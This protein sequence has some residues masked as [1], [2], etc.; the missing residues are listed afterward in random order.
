M[1]NQYIYNNVQNPI[2]N[3]STI[4]KMIE[5]YASSS[6]EISLIKTNSSKAE[7]VSN[8][9][10]VNKLYSKL[11]NTW[12][13]SI[14]T[15][16]QDQIRNAISKGIYDKSIYKLYDFLKKVPNVK[17]ISEINRIFN[18]N[19]KDEELLHAI[20]EY[21]WDN[22]S[23]FKETVITARDVNAKK[24]PTSTIEHVLYINS[25]NYDLH[26]LANLFI[27]K[28][29][30]KNLPYTL[31]LSE[32]ENRDDKI[33]IYSDSKNLSEFVEILRT[34]EKEYPETI[35]RCGHPPIIS[36]KVTN[37]LGYGRISPDSKKTDF[38]EKRVKVI[39]KSIDQELRNWYKENKNQIDITDKKGNKK[40]LTE[41]LS[42]QIAKEE[43][44]KMK[45]CL[46]QSEYEKQF[47]AEKYGYTEIDLNKASFRQRLYLEISKKMEKIITDYSRGN[48][49]TEDVTVL[50][51]SGKQYTIPS[52]RIVTEI[53]K[54]ISIVN[55]ADKE[56]VKKVRTR[57]IENSSKEGIDSSK[58]C[59]D[60]LSQSQKQDNRAIV[61]E[62]QANIKKLASEYGCQFPRNIEVNESIEHYSMYLKLFCTRILRPAMDKKQQARVVAERQPVI[63]TSAPRTVEMK[64][65]HHRYTAMSD[66]EII[67]SQQKLGIYI[68]PKRKIK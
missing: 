27:D 42:L 38:I 68:A 25:S 30:E 21:R 39:E 67:A 51:E 35:K 56:F 59:C 12:K 47:N 33:A 57:I 22:K 19:Y 66:A 64:K 16:S 2:D 10:E 3:L 36:G 13:N 40:S 52:Y 1:T 43:I 44:E 41:Y 53:R 46:P 62:Q 45:I 65:G 26:K 17:N 50:L 31:T 29:T 14:L 60:R 32:Q 11:F 55:A 49:I 20:N 18:T 28:C 54:S 8:Q 23:T 63:K 15:L 61:L 4:S 34:I 48:T 5:A 6:T 24:F 37:W 9:T 58:F 7:V